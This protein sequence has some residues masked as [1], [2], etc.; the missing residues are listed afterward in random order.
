VDS[1]FA[2]VV[3]QQTDIVKIVGSYITL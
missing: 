3:K 1:D 2:K